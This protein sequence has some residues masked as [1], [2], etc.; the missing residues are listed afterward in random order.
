MPVEVVIPLPP[1][2]NHM[3][4]HQNNRKFKT[5]AYRAWEREAGRAL[6]PYKRYFR[7]MYR[8]PYGYVARFYFPDNKRRDADNRLKALQDMASSVLG[9]DDKEIIYGQ[10]HKRMDPDS[11]RCELL[12]WGDV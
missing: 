3:Y 11:P 6:L 1:T 9:F 2:V 8:P 4:R 12:I 7:E 10:F 5:E